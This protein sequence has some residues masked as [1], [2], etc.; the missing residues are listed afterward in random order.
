MPK[1]STKP[2]KSQSNLVSC[3]YFLP[4]DYI[5]TFFLQPTVRR[6]YSVVFINAQNDSLDPILDE[7]YTE[8]VLQKRRAIVAIN[9]DYVVMKIMSEKGI[10]V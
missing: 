9:M 5:N 2:K 3:V 6:D 7:F 4:L 10:N 1:P 8:A